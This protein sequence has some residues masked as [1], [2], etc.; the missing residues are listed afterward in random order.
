MNERR[1]VSREAFRLFCFWAVVAL[2]VAGLG[3]WHGGRASMRTEITQ[4]IKAQQVAPARVIKVPQ[5]GLVIVPF[6]KGILSWS[7]RKA[8]ARVAEYR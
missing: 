1:G 6:E 5:I 8:P 7:D 4:T 3:A 2:I